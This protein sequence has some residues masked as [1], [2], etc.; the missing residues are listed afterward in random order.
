MPPQPILD[1]SSIDQSTVAVTR[2]QIY[3][4][5]PH[6]HEFQQ[7]DGIFFVDRRQ[8]MMAGFRDVR[9][10]EFWV[11]GHIPGRPVFPGVLMIETAAQLVSY[12]VMSQDDQGRFLGFGGVDRVK[13]RGQVV[14]GDRIVMLGKM[15]SARLG[16]RYTG[17]T[18]GFVNGQMVYEGVITGMFIGK[19]P[20]P[21]RASRSGG[22]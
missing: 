19:L 10:D 5:N 12:Y 17:L 16:R 7:L 21:L 6:R 1:V 20:A 9:D 15:V 8:G 2:E 18:Q 4:V 22:S 11:R 3:Q 13:F 14:P